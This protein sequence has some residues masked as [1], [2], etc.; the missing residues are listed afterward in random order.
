MPNA[1]FLI[2][3][4]EGDSPETEYW[5]AAKLQRYYDCNSI[6]VLSHS[7]NY[8]IGSGIFESIRQFFNEDRA[9][10]N[11]V[12]EVH[13][14]GGL[15]AAC[16]YFMARRYP[17]NIERIFFIGGAP[18]NAMTTPAKLFHRYVS[19]AWY[20]SKIPYF[21]DDPNPE[22][23]KTIAKIKASSTKTMRRDP[24][25]YCNQLRF[26]GEWNPMSRWRV[27][28][29]IEAFFVPNGDTVR[30]KWW[31]N[32]YDNKKAKSI[33]SKYGVKSTQKPAYNFSFYSMMPA[34]ALFEVMDIARENL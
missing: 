18:A 11:S 28:K 1:N 5:Y 8:D 4:A 26:I 24:K 15:G 7:N 20:Y 23:D 34:E 13:A 27:P 32:T 10:R 30:P 29:N 31:D 12:F 16:A 25:L 21:A 2:I 3:P 9:R 14:Q 17:E 33:W 6:S 22:N 19:L